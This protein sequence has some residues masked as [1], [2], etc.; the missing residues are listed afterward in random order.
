MTLYVVLG[1]GDMPAKEVTHQLD[2]LWYKAEA[3]DQNFWFVLEAKEAPTPTDLELVSFFAKFGISYG[4]IV[5]KGMTVPADYVGVAELIDVERVLDGV[6]FAIHE[7]PEQDGEAAVLL[8]LFQ[9]I[10]EDDPADAALISAV[11]LALQAGVEVFA[12]NDSLERVAMTQPIP[13]N[14]P[15]PAPAKSPKRPAKPAPAPAPAEASPEMDALTRTILDGMRAPEVKALAEGMG[16]PYTN[17]PDTI[18]TI[19]DLISGEDQLTPE[20][21]AVTDLTDVRE[22]I[23]LGPDQV[24]QTVDTG[25]ERIAALF[26]PVSNSFVV[27]HSSTG[28]RTMWVP[29]TIVAKWID[30]L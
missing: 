12:L 8:C 24:V 9:N 25:D 19:L 4:L 27:I 23:D 2:D 13:L 18:E 21:P 28:M 29:D 14:T 1:D 11:T 20:E 7:M 22:D 3:E 17:K 5:P 6:D 15:E 16:L 26:E 10:K 30:S